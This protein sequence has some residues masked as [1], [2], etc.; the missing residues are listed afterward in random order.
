[1]SGD[2][3]G[4]ARVAGFVL[5]CLVHL[6]PFA[7]LVAGVALIAGA[8]VL[9]VP[10]GVIALDLAWVLRPRFGRLPSGAAVLGREDAPHLYGLLDRIGAEIGAPA[11]DVIVVSGAANAAFGT[12]G[13]RRRRVVEIGYPLW[14]ILTPAERVSVLAHEMAHS[15]NGD[16][17]HGL[18]VG[19]A[20]HSL[21]ELRQVTRFDWEPGDGVSR[22]L[23][24]GLLALVGLPVRGLAF[25]LELLLNRA[26]QRAEHRADDIQARVAGT[27]ATLSTLDALTTRVAWADRFLATRTLAVGRQDLWA[28]LRAALDEVTEEEFDALRAEA[29]KERTRVDQTHP[30]TC[31]RIERVAASPFAEARVRAEAMDAVDAELAGPAARVAQALREDAQSALYW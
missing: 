21:A 13:P 15:R 30:P 7:L 24:E 31:V 28:D 3:P 22:L 29:R 11:T 23:A 17:R 2:G 5:A 8:T 16:D 4:P 1:M 6:T 12:Y 14:M 26:S 9:S 18:V 10:A 19:G 20:L 27:E 25:V